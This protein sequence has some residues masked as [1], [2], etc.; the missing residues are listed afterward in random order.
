VTGTTLSYADR[1]A[2]AFTAV[3]QGLAD[4]IPALLAAAIV[5]VLTW[6]VARIVFGITRRVL[7]RRSTAGHVDLF[8]ARFVKGCVYAIGAVVALGVLGIDLTALAAS[9]GLASLTLGFALRDVLANSVSGVM[10]LLQRPFRIGDSI[11][12]AGVDGVVEDVRI[13]DTVVRIPDGRRAYVPNTT[14]FNDVVVNSS[15]RTQRRFEIALF[16]PVDADLGRAC[17]AVRDAV[18]STAAVLDE[19]SAEASVATIGTAWARIVAHGWVD[20]QES[21]LDATRAEALAAAD[22]ALARI[23]PRTR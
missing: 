2:V 9:L 17:E 7:A 14:V 22:A 3:A 19:P 10:L 8:V 5:L 6:L 21:G 23:A 15:D 12:V 4:R 18:A 16:A 13:R 1:I 20:T 11:S